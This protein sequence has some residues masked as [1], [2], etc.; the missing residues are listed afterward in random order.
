MSERITTRGF[1]AVAG[2]MRE[3]RRS[4]AI[5]ETFERGNVCTGGNLLGILRVR[6]ST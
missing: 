5:K 6:E 4:A 3:A 2:R 1:S